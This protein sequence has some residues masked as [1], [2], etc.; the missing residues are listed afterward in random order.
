LAAIVFNVDIVVAYGAGVRMSISILPIRE[1]KGG[2]GDQFEVGLGEKGA[3]EGMLLMQIHKPAG[4]PPLFLELGMQLLR[5]AVFQFPQET[6]LPGGRGQDVCPDLKFKGIDRWGQP[7]GC[8][9]I[10][11]EVPQL[12]DS[13]QGLGARSGSIHR[14]RGEEW[15]KSQPQAG[16]ERNARAGLHG[17]NSSGLSSPIPV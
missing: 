3:N 11:L 9:G 10:A 5:G 17:S 2:S 4:G 1:P 14:L 16:E 6:P 12:V 13:G 15:A 8:Q 7:R